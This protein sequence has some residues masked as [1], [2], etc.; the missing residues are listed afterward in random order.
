[1]FI[2]DAIANLMHLDILELNFLLRVRH[3]TTPL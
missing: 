1:M 2:L 3:I